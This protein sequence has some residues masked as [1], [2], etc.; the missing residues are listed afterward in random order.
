MSTSHDYVLIMAG[1]AGTRFWP[2][3]R[4]SSPKQFLDIFRR[5]RT[6]F[7]DT[8]A[9]ARKIVPEENIWVVTNREY[10]EIA[11]RQAPQI[12]TSQILGEPIIR[13]TAPAIAYGTWSIHVKDPHARVAIMPADHYIAPAERFCDD[14]RKAIEAADQYDGIITLGITPTY[15]ATGY[16]YIQV[17]HHRVIGRFHR[18]ISFLEKPN[19]TLARQ[20][21]ENKGEFYWNSGIFIAATRIL[22][23]TFRLHLPTIY[24]QFSCLIPRLQRH[25]ETEVLDEVYAAVPSISIDYGI[26]EK[27]MHVLCLPVSFQ[28]SDVGT[29]RAVY[30]LLD[31]DL[32]GNVVLGKGVHLRKTHRSLVY[33]HQNDHILVLNEVEGMAVVYTDDA[34]LITSLDKDQEVRS[35]VNEI[36]AYYG[37]KYV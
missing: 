32:N 25:T 33:V 15:P 9:R 1:G 12:P 10:V 28:W 6:L 20:F 5:G 31:K 11:R 37:G 29:W 23:E 14:I 13:N 4:R 17:D 26:M 34:L 8:V 2:L 19:L 3:S 18:A 22:I 36:T 27:C 35:L 7:Q 24:H 16:G 30:Q 21:I